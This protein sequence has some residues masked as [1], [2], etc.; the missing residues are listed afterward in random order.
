MLI[1][2]LEAARFD[3]FCDEARDADDFSPEELASAYLSERCAPH[4]GR[5]TDP[6]AVIHNLILNGQVAEYIGALDDEPRLGPEL[7]TPAADEEPLTDQDLKRIAT[8]RA[9]LGLPVG[10]DDPEDDGGGNEPEGGAQLSLP[11]MPDPIVSAVIADGQVVMFEDHRSDEPESV[12][13]MDAEDPSQWDAVEQALATD[14][15]FDSSDNANP[16][17]PTLDHWDWPPPA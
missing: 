1:R 16:D 4:R 12:H 11:L 3:T 15:A 14:D 2:K 8:Q 13:E 17:E 7:A 6:D 10:D 9:E 5:P